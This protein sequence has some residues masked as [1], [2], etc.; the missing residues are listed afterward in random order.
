MKTTTSLL[1]ALCFVIWSCNNSANTET[2]TDSS[3][4]IHDSLNGSP[5][6]SGSGNMNMTM[7]TDAA[8]SAFLMKVANV[9]MAEVQLGQ[10]AQT[11]GTYQ[12]VKD[13]AAMMVQDHTA[14]NDKV[15]S[16]ATQRSVT[17]PSVVDQDHQKMI[18]D[19]NK[20]NG[21]AFDKSYIDAMVKGHEKVIKDFQDASGKVGDT[22]V[23]SFITNTLPTLQ[24]HLDS[25][26]AVQKRLK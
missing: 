4:T 25:A 13:F 20:K 23:K 6:D 21:K 5:K 1:L 9:G 26:K 2:K 12:G 7:P 24:T 3:G 16:L 18:D 14:A 17:L 10:I 22:E 11:K 15:K 19:L 8:S